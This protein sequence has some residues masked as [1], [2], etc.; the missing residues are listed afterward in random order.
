M[1][2][3]VVMIAKDR[4]RL[5][6]Q[7]IRTLYRNTP[8][9]SFNLM[10]VDD[11]SQEETR[12]FIQSFEHYENFAAIHLAKSIGILGFL[13][14]VG[15]WA[16]ERHFGRGTHIHF[17]DNDVAFFPD[18]LMRMEDQWPHLG[19]IVGGNQHPYHQTTLG[20]GYFR[21]VDAVAGY[22]MMM[23]WEA[24]DKFGP[25]DQHAK[26]TGQS[27]DFAICQKVVKAGWPVGY[28]HPPILA[29]C[30]ITSGGKPAIGAELFERVPGII[31]E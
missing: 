22:S 14:N 18:W 11:G 6:A 29:H 12:R 24:W 28:I 7:A 1:K 20:W 9:E 5:T 26:G 15:A 3:N 8:R 21:E 31:Y 10:V 16:S 2:F 23:E 17:I 30:G 4:P 19:V 27:E 25:F 13:R